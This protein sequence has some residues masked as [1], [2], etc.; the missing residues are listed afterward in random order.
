M[1]IRVVRSGGLAGLRSERDVDT[2]ALPPGLAT[3]LEDRLRLLNFFEL[4]PKQ[5][6]GMPD[7][8]MYRVRAD[9][10]AGAHAVTFDDDAR[11]AGLRELAELVLGAAVGE[12]G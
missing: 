11:N 6:R 9:D 1:R 4:P 8:I 12:A 5:V 10:F 3:Q 2:A 7:A